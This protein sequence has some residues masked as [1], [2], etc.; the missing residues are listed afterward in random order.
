[1]STPVPP[2][3]AKSSLIQTSQLVFPAAVQVCRKTPLTLPDMDMSHFLATELR[4][5]KLDKLY[6]QLWLAGLPIPAHSLQRQRLMGREMY[7]TE[8]PDEHLVWHKTKLL[9][10]PLPDYL[11]CHSFWIENLCSDVTLYWSAAGFLLSYTWLIGHKS[12]FVLACEINLIPP[13]VDWLAWTEFMKD[14][15]RN[16]DLSTL[17]QVD[18]RYHYGEL[19]LSR[20]NSLMRFLPSM[21]SYENFI[22]GY[23]STSRWYQALFE[24]NFSWLLTAFVFISVPLSAMQ[25]G[26]STQQLGGNQ[27]FDTLAYGIALLAIALVLL[28]TGAAWLVW[29]VLFCYHLFST[30]KLDRRIRVE[31][32]IGLSRA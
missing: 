23:L 7:I 2:F 24:R 28:A 31:R 32:N 16:I 12:D 20:L 5:R 18:R 3:S 17:A 26:L 4:T 8:R 13:G 6:E 1:M 27:P 9:V 21:W 19:R 30:I 25:V 11:L 22:W 15:L 10:K 29:F 14:F